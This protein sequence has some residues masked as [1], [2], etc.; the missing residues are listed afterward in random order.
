M[1]ATHSLN[2]HCLIIGA[3]HAGMQT[4]ASLRQNGYSG[5]IT[6]LGDELSLPYHRPPLSKEY[7]A[8]EKALDDILLRPE[9]FYTKNNINVKLGWHANAIDKQQRLVFAQNAEGKT[10]TLSY[11]TLVL[12]T[13]ARI[14]PLPE[15]ITPLANVMV[16]PDI[17]YLRHAAHAQAIFTRAQTAKSVIIIG[18]GY[19]GLE[20]AASLRKQGIEVRIIEAAPRLLARVSAPQTAQFYQSLHEKNGVHIHVDTQINSLPQNASQNG[21]CVQTQQGEI[22]SA[23]MMIIGIG[24][25]ANTQLAKSAD[26]T[27]AEPP[28]QGITCNP[29]MQS[30]NKHI[31][32]VGDVSWH[33]NSLYQRYIRL[34]SVPNALEQAKIAA[35]SITGN[36]QPYNSLPWFWSDQ[37]D[38]KL[39]IAGLMQGYDN[40]CIRGELDTEHKGAVFYFKGDKLLCVDAFNDPRTFM[41]AKKVLASGQS[42]KKSLLENSKIALKE[43]I[44]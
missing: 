2:S 31:Y 6:L 14:R 36:P 3:S 34:E 27:M 26:L 32:A 17:F 5:D 10:L 38:V 8:G 37:Y 15:S 23:D 30:S 11:D 44:V 24:V 21:L 1:N 9:S 43:I 42:F 19:I 33:Y 28:E 4:C 22:F 40:I 29:Y 13:G 16:H 18:G 39:Q 12:C 35:L 25:I 41:L 7:M 20:A